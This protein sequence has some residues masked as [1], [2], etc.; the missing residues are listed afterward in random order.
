VA[1][2]LKRVVVAWS[3][4]IRQRPKAFVGLVQLK[5]Y[6]ENTAIARIEANCYKDRGE[7]VAAPEFAGIDRLG[8][9]EEHQD[10]Q[11]RTDKFSYNSPPTVQG[12]QNIGAAA[13]FKHADLVGRAHLGRFDPQCAKPTGG[14]IAAEL[15]TLPLGQHWRAAGLFMD[16]AGSVD[17]M[18]NR[19]ESYI[20]TL[21]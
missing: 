9:A 14:A 13:E 4:G 3:A 18:R 19:G 17:E 10:R 12:G 6:L 11:H 1:P 2:S 21:A 8:S 20:E 16:P 7:R 5:L 15:R